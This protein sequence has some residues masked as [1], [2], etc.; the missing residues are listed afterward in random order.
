MFLRIMQFRYILAPIEGMTNSNFRKL[1]CKYGA[2]LTFTEMARIDAL[3]RKNKSTLDRIRLDDNTPTTIQL[4]GNKEELLKKFLSTYEPCQGFKGFDLNLGCPSP[5]FVNKGLGCAMI[6]R[7]SKVKKLIDTIKDA[8]YKA[9]IKMR[10]GANKFEKQRKN[11]LNLIENVDADFFIVHARH[12]K[13]G[14]NEE[15]DLKVYPECVASGKSIIANGDI[16]TK[17]DVDSLK[18]IGGS[19]VMIGR[20]AIRNPGIFGIKKGIKVPPIE[21]LRKEYEQM[22]IENKEYRYQHTILK[23]LGNDEKFIEEEA[24]TL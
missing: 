18:D 4:I 10:L 2:D 12:G 3:A 14:F 5:S 24:S 7:I 20:V 13:Q 19:G 9:S 16:K 22:I 17:E 23:Y 21:E 6:K 11:Y 1:A 8:G 15:A